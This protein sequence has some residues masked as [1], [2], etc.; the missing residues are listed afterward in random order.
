VL[1]VDASVAI[2]WVV[3]EQHSE[4]AIALLYEDLAAPELWLTEVANALWARQ[5]RRLLNEEEARTCL[6]E[7]IS[8]PVNAL[9]MIELVALAFDVAVV[10]RHPVYDCCYLAAAQVHDCALVT[11]DGRL[12]RRVARHPELARRVRLLWELD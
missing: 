12:A 7:L 1:I 10:L 11:A 3:T 5:A 2:K 4:S 9:P 6:R 8:A